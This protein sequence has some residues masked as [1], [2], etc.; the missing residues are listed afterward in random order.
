[1][2]LEKEEDKT[3]KQLDELKNMVEKMLKRFEEQVKD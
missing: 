1:L 3:E 2:E